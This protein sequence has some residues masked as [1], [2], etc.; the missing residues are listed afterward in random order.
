MIA[1]PSEDQN[2]SDHQQELSRVILSLLDEFLQEHDRQRR[3]DRVE[4]I[5]C[6]LDETVEEEQGGGFWF[7]Y[8]EVPVCLGDI[9]SH[10]YKTTQENPSS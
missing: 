1:Q 10:W 4:E 9:I 8:R 3:D 2:G 7:F 6:A 5:E